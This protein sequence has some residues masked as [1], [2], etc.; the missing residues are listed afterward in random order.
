M[1]SYQNL[2][3]FPQEVRLALYCCPVLESMW[4]Q[5]PMWNHDTLRGSTDLADFVFVGNKDPE[6]FSLV[7]WNLWNRCNNLRLGKLFLPLD[8][9]LEHSRERQ[10]E[11]LSCP[12]TSSLH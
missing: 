6:L 11:A 2:K 7:I 4:R 5:I 10:I 3:I 12:V 9:I 1:R 8:K